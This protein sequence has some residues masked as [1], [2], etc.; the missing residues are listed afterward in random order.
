MIVCVCV[1][2][3]YYSD[4]YMVCLATQQPVL[5]GVESDD[6]ARRVRELAA[7]RVERFPA[8]VA[9]AHDRVRLRPPMSEHTLEAQAARVAAPRAER[10]RHLRE[11]AAAVQVA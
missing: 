11:Q 5:G 8:K 3:M 6:A 7:G 1:C 2:V 9:E 10:C 4:I